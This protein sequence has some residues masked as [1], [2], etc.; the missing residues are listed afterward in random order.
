MSFGAPAG[1]CASV[2]PPQK[3]VHLQASNG[4]LRCNKP[5]VEA[6]MMLF[7]S[8]KKKPRSRVGGPGRDTRRWPDAH[9]TIRGR[10]VVSGPLEKT[11]TPGVYRRQN[12]TGKPTYVV[13]YRD[14]R[15]RSQQATARTYDEARQKRHDLAAAAKRGEL[16]QDAQDRNVAFEAYAKEWV[17]RY[18]G[19]GRRGF[20]EGTRDEYRRLLDA[21]AFRFFSP[22]L[23]LV[24]LTP[25]RVA[26][27]VAWLAQQTT[28]TRTTPAGKVLSGG[29]PLS[30]NTIRNA[31]NP[32][33][34]LCASALQE[35]LIRS[36]P[37]HGVALPHRPRAEDDDA[38]EVRALS[39]EQLAAFLAIVSERH[40]L[41]FR[42]L[43]VTGLRVSELLGLRWRDLRLDGGEPC[44]RVRRALV[45]GRVEPP[46]T[47]YG[48]RDVPLPHELVVALRQQRKD[49]EWHEADD[50]VFPNQVGRAH[51]VENLRRRVLSP[52]AEEAGVPWAGFHTFRHTCA[53]ML[54]ERGRS[55][56]QV[57]RWL[58][59]HSAAFT[60]STYVHLLP[61]D[62]TAPLDLD[63]EL[64]QHN[65]STT[66]P[67]PTPD[68][69][70]EFTDGKPVE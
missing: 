45:R 69:E 1:R 47:R 28:P 52:A 13:T 5:S 63:A 58:G 60:L 49:T 32:V 16:D 8:C 50:L 17:E 18:H 56:V 61:G 42:L 25:R 33:R 23:K 14:S 9:R 6:G 37:T 46:K 39:R 51:N 57:Q 29:E 7:E 34:A 54:F 59:H 44:V 35:G 66:D 68:N 70:G 62:V 30:D 12:R 15:G 22:R 11:K 10:P 53:S 55:A 2:V 43:A 26:E 36:N 40:R 48:K 20:R 3:G 31:L 38:E 65:G 41:M 67:T 21:Y 64:P 19:R 24:A 4:D 27:F